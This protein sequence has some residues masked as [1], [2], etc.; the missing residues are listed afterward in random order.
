MKFQER[1]GEKETEK[2]MW[3]VNVKAG[4]EASSP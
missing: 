1:R 2:S 4:E 3:K